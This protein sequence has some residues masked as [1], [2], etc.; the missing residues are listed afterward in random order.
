M[1]RSRRSVLHLGALSL[2]GLAGCVD[3]GSNV[4]YPSTATTDATTTTTATTRTATTPTET[5]RTTTTTT[6]LPVEHP[7]LA[8]ETGRVVDGVAWFAREYD[9]AVREYRRA[10]DRVRATVGQLRNAARVTEN[11]LRRLESTT[12]GVAEVASSRLAPRFPVD[13][14]LSTANNEFVRNVRTFARRGDVDRAQA[15]L[16]RMYRFYLTAGTRRYVDR[17]FSAAPIRDAVF[18]HLKA[19]DENRLALFE[20][21]YPDARYG[22]YAYA[23]E[24]R[25]LVDDPYD[26]R[27]RLRLGRLFDAVGVEA[28]RVDSLYVVPHVLPG[29]FRFARAETLRSL[30]VYVQRFESRRAARQAVATM[31][32]GPP[33]TEGT[34]TL[35][36][37]EW[38]RIFFFHEDDIRYAHLLR[39]GRHVVTAGPTET[40]WEDRD[41]DGRW[42]D[43]LELTWL[44]NDPPS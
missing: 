15:E 40:P 1:S 17:E 4:T 39:A 10:V 28:G 18:D 22:A 2:A 21:G 3:T 42:S 14:R 23:G 37:R 11:D 26:E 41:D 19:D 8:A 35:A 30:A 24:D 36:G 25:H 16:D 31:F 44:W 5:T 33:V 43:P 29:R 34:E 32:D 20:L 6:V 27:D 13:G 12:G 38:R 7:R 9:D